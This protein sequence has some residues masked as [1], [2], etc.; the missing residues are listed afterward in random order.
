MQTLTTP[1]QQIAF[2]RKWSAA[3]RSGMYR[4]ARGKMFLKPRKQAKEQAIGYCC[5]GVA[6]DMVDC[7]T[8]EEIKTTIKKDIGMLSEMW[9]VSKTR[10]KAPSLLPGNGTDLLRK[11]VDHNDSITFISMNDDLKMSFDEIADVV[12]I[13]VLEMTAK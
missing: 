13:L 3:L 4:Q 5:L 6:L 7:I 11:Y 10:F 9:A 8:P 2:L 12:D 1:K